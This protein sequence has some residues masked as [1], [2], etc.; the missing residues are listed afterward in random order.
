MYLQIPI[1]YPIPLQEH[2]PWWRA[3]LKNWKYIYQVEVTNTAKIC[4]K[5]NSN[6]AIT[7]LVQQTISLHGM[8]CDSSK[9]YDI[10]AKYTFQCSVPIPGRFVT[11]KLKGRSS[12]Q[13][14]LCFVDIR[15]LGE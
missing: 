1:S 8:Q 14:V 9:K 13:L 2:N 12:N 10:R 7:A 6:T 3:D 5:G 4:D 15:N 11:I